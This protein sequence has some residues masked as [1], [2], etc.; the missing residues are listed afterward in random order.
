MIQTTL[1]AVPRLESMAQSTML[2]IGWISTM[3]NIS[4][5]KAT[6][7]P[8]SAMAAKPVTVS[9]MRSL[10]RGSATAEAGL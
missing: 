8:S 10:S 9:I 7:N 1:L 4:T 2:Q 5:P 6:K 3:N